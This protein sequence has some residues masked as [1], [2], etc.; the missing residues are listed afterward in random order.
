MR[1]LFLKGVSD[2]CVKRHAL[3]RGMRCGAAALAR[4]QSGFVANS[5]M[6][7]ADAEAARAAAAHLAAL[8]AADAAALAQNAYYCSCVQVY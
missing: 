7:A 6:E 8:R 1:N 3:T 4:A 5:E 2:F